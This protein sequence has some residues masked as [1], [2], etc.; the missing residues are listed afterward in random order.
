MSTFKI[1]VG[2]KDQWRPFNDYC[3]LY[4]PVRYTTQ[5]T[6][7]FASLDEMKVITTRL[8]HELEDERKTS[9][10]ALEDEE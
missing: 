4:V 5:L 10:A 7:L 3:K 9:L 8:K 1:F 6:G 2:N